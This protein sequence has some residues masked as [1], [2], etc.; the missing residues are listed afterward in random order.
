MREDFDIEHGQ[1]VLLAASTGGHLQQLYRLREKIPAAPGSLW[2]TFENA[3]SKSLLAGERAVFV[4]YIASR[5]FFGALRSI[6]KVIGIMRREEF[7]V[8]ISTGAAIAAVTLPIAKAMG[9]DAIYI[10]SVARFDGP[11]LTGKFLSRIPGIRLFTQHEEWSDRNWEFRTSVLSQYETTTPSAAVD[12]KQIFVTLGTIKPFRFDRMVDRLKQVVPANVNIIWQLG[13]TERRDLPGTVFDSM[14]VTDFDL[15][16][17]DSDVVITHAGVGSAL[18]ILDS[19]KCPV[20]V[21]R[22]SVHGEHVDDHQLQISGSLSRLGLA[23]SADASDLT[24]SDILKAAK[25]I[26]VR[27]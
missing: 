3:Q 27:E 19:G 21:P 23:V 14:S 18:R 5:D 9:K 25:Q 10:E 13:S 15:M 8:A 4:P 6:P 26:V 20:M 12:V 2:I 7:D 24:Y 17:Q 22:R 11:S 16:V 1:S